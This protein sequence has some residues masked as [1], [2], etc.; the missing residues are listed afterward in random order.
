MTKYIN[1]DEMLADENEAYLNAQ[2]KITD[3][4]TRDIN[5]VIHT[6]LQKL[7]ADAPSA[8]VVEMTLE[9][10]IDYLRS[11]GWMQEHDRQ[12]MEMGKEA[13]H[14]RWIVAETEFA[15]NSAEYPI[16]YKCSK[17]GHIVKA[18]LEGNFCPDCGARM[19]LDE[20]TE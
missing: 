4:I 19:D 1:C 6:K 13:R 10:A 7:L 5:Y 8:D 14:G 20:V 2:S 9:N 18:G 16:S 17:C 15:W 11:V 12:M 3:K